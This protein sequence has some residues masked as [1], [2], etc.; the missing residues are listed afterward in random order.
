MNEETTKGVILKSK[1]YKENAALVTVYTLEFGRITLVARGV[2]KMTSKNAPSVVPLTLSELSINPRSGLSTLIRGQVIDHYRHI[3]SSIESEIVA[4][5]LL[6]YFYRYKEENEPDQE[7]YDFLTGIL[8]A[9]DNGYPYHLIYALINIYI[10]KDNGIALE[11]DGCVRCGEKR[12]TAFSIEDG[13]FICEAHRHI[14]DQ[15]YT[16]SVLKALRHLYKV[17]IKNIDTIHINEED[18]TVLDKLFGH[19]IDEYCG[20]RLKSHTF[21]QQIM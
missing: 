21:I 18:L 1:A 9:L 17:D 6:E 8:E 14:R 19:Y 10:I 12:V 2:K 7:A 20:I 3:K 11:V 13:G 4:D 5:Y 15:R 16:P